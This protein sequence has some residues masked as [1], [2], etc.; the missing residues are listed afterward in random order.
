MLGEPTAGTAYELL[1]VLIDGQLN[2]R[3]AGFDTGLAIVESYLV[4]DSVL[5]VEDG[6]LESVIAWGR[7]A[8]QSTDGVNELLGNGF[9]R[10]R[11]LAS[12]GAPSPWAAGASATWRRY[13]YGDYLDPI[14]ALEFRGQINASD[15]DIDMVEAGYS[16]GGSIGWLW[17]PNRASRFRVAGDVRM[18]AQEMFVGITFDVNYGF[19]D[20]VFL[21]GGAMPAAIPE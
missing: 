15:D 21:S 9:A 16:V 17:I 8:R 18:I 5:P 1:Q 3:Q 11:L 20:S 10:I 13:F 14:G 6:R 2:R 12:D 7:F 4:R 19:L